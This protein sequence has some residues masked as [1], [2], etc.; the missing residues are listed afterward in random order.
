MMMKKGMKEK[1]AVIGLLGMLAAA[2]PA[3]GQ[4]ESV[5]PGINDKFVNDPSP[6]K[7]VERFEKE[8][9]EIYNKRD[10]IVAATNF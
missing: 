5:R 8:G 9:R 7:W 4:E 1:W 10:E 6:E 3:G 2:W